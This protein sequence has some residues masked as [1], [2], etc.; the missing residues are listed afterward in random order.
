M[1]GKSKCK[2]LK[3]I[4]REIAKQNDIDLVIEECRFKGECSGT[5][6]KC[7]SEVRYLEKELERRRSLGKKVAVAGLVATLAASA[8]GCSLV[9]PT[10]P[11][12][13]DI[14][15]GIFVDP[16]A[17]YITPTEDGYFSKGLPY[18]AEI[19]NT[20]EKDRIELLKRFNR[21][22]FLHKWSENFTVW[23]TD[24]DLYSITTN[25]SEFNISIT[26]DPQGRPIDISTGFIPITEE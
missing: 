5:C 2:I 9:D 26:F 4:R 14:V 10:P 3:D 20:P 8:A 23:T 21:V 17:S 11:L 25:K 15:E 18:L 7:E 16:N 13:G 19:L 12:E 24:T 1:N 6:P 22:D